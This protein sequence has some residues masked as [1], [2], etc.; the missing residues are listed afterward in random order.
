MLLSLMRECGTLSTNDVVCSGFGYL[1]ATF[2][3][4]SKVRSHPTI[5]DGG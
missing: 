3:S 1:N 5:G 4:S 2:I